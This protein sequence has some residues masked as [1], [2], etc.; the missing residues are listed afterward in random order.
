MCLNT[1]D[2]SISEAIRGCENL[3]SWISRFKAKEA[4]LKN[5]RIRDL[6]REVLI[7]HAANRAQEELELAQRLN[8]QRWMQLK[9]RQLEK[10]AKCAAFVNFCTCDLNCMDVD[11]EESKKIDEF[12]EFKRKRRPSILK[13]NAKRIKT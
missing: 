10:C 7:L 8:R 12:L 3:S 1:S 4:I 2:Y 13:P 9:A 5:S 6:R 11:S